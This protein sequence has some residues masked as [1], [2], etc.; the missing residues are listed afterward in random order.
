MTSIEDRVRTCLK[1]AGLQSLPK[2]N[3]EKLEKYGFDSVIK[4]LSLIQIENEFK[5]QISPSILNQNSLETISDF[6]QL[7]T[8]K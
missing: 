1:K 5:V 7:L 6:C 2:E 4:I 3:T 8:Q